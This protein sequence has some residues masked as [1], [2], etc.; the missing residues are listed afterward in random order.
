MMAF[1]MVLP[2][3]YKLNIIHGRSGVIY[4]NENNE[5]DDQ[6]V[7]ILHCRNHYSALIS[8]S[9]R[10][11]INPRYIIGKETYTIVDFG[12]KGNCF[13]LAI[14]G[15]LRAL[16]PNQKYDHNTLRNEVSRWYIQ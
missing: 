10:V 13:F 14:A 11:E 8:S 4:G 5:K 3:G 7:L 16:F 2:Q 6:I 9:K 12:G 1:N 15:S